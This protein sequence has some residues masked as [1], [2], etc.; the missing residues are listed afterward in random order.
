MHAC[1]HMHVYR[2]MC[3]L[4]CYLCVANCHVNLFCTQWC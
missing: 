4:I 1:V 2:Y 3:A